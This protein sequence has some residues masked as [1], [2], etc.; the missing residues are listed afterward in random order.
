LFNDVF[1]SFNG[2]NREGP[3]HALGGGCE[4]RLVE[5]LFERRGLDDKALSLD[6]P[7]ESEELAPPRRG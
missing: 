5:V 7:S 1:V 6:K 2:G 4:G 3:S